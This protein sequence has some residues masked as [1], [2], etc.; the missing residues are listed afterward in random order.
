V[1]SA[2]PK[3][4]GIGRHRT[5]ASASNRRP[6]TPVVSWADCRRKLAVQPV[7]SEKLLS[8]TQLFG[9]GFLPLKLSLLRI[10]WRAT[11]CLQKG[12]LKLALG[13]H[14]LR[15]LVRR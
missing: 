11:R 15:Y 3:Q 6:T 2:L 8:C 10:A 12:T 13:Q 7:L 5:L 14:A 1:D 4:V 9:A